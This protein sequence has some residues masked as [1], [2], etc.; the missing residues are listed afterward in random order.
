MPKHIYVGYQ[1]YSLPLT[2]EIFYYKT[3][4]SVKPNVP[5]KPPPTKITKEIKM[6]KSLKGSDMSH[7]DIPA[8]VTQPKSI[9]KASIQHNKENDEVSFVSGENF[10]FNKP[11]STPY[12]QSPIAGPM[13]R[14]DSK[15]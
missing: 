9:L 7:K 14:Y 8:K 10:D 2:A 11:I 3:L 15:F 1:R 6:K 12:L 4:F 5:I 13:T